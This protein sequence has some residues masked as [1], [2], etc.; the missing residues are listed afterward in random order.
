MGFG[1]NRI[2]S[3]TMNKTGLSSVQMKGMS[4]LQGICGA[5]RE[6]GTPNAAAF[7][8]S[9]PK[10]FPPAR[11]VTFVAPCVPQSLKCMGMGVVSFHNPQS[12]HGATTP[13][14]GGAALARAAA[15]TR[16]CFARRMT[17]GGTPRYSCH[18]SG[19][20]TLRLKFARG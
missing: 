20:P 15:A 11:I 12:Q 5:K 17:S 8:P 19:D 16:P 9:A 13:R 2:V 10:P 4:M 1:T 7:P 18:T 14:G 3:K 6:G